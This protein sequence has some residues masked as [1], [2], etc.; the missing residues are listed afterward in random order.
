MRIARMVLSLLFAVPIYIFKFWWLGRHRSKAEL[1]EYIKKKTKR[2]NKAGKVKIEVHG[3]ENIPKEDGFVVF[4][5]HQGLYDAMVF[6]DV[7]PRPV[8]FVVK[9]EVRNVVLVKQVIDGL[10]CLVIDRSDLRQSMTVIKEMTRRVGEGENIVIFAE[11]TRSKL[12][13]R[14]LD[15][16][17][18]SFKSA[19]KA[20]CPI[21]PCAL[22]DSFLP[23]DS[24]TLKPVNVKVFYLPP[25]Y[26]EEYK[27]M[28][29]LEIAVEVKR[30][31][32]E[33]LIKESPNPNGSTLAP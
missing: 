2:A 15:M 6:L 13:N 27:D 20:K 26:Y 22:V 12:G 25:M 17:G 4:P 10:G 33:V 8:S 29:T 21:V 30:R 11:G 7:F 3:E 19:V 9:K 28:S 14:M 16:K 24:K 31:I 18:G 1:F 23:F 32:E 5:N